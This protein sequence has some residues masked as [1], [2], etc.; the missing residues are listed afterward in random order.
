VAAVIV[1][2]VCCFW[3]VAGVTGMERCFLIAIYSDV[4]GIFDSDAYVYV[5]LEWCFFFWMY[6]F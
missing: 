2:G 6:R 4:T 1:P 5:F 3:G